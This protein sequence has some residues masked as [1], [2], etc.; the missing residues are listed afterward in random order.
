VAV[1]PNGTESKASNEVMSSLI[2]GLVVIKNVSVRTTDPVNGSVYLEWGKPDTILSGGPFRYMIYRA[3]GIAGTNYQP[4][5]SLP[6]LN[7]NDTVYIDTLINTQSK[8][9]IYKI[10]ILNNENPIPEPSFASS[11]FLTAIPGDR[12]SKLTFSRNVPWINIR[13]DIFRFNET[14]SKYDSIGTTNLL[15]YTDTNRDNG[16]EYWY[17]VRST[18]AYQSPSLPKN[19][20]NFSETASVKPFDNEPPCR[21]GLNVSSQCDIPSNTLRWNVTDPFCLS[22]IA[23]YNIHY[24]LPNTEK[25]TIIYKADK[26]TFLYVHEKVVAGCYAVT[27]YDSTGNE[28]PESEWQWICV[29]SCKFYEIPNVFTPNED[30]FNDRLVARTSGLVEK[31]DFKLFNRN[32]LQLFRTTDPKINWDGTYKGKIVSPGVYFYQCDVWERRITGLEM[33][34]LSGFVHVITEKGATN[35]VVNK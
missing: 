11:L 29:D 13:Y 9:Y 20:I 24:K 10:E 33:F 16:K 30:T 22:D 3:E 14:T 26:S 35:K 2:S 17:L 31:I 27:A 7:L 15:S 25:D 23:G 6:T 1:Y 28:I 5:P 8:A 18:G 19:L 12:K 21:P 4:I 32:G 34:H